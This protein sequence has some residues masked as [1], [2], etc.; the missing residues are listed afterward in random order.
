MSWSLSAFAD[1]AGPSTDEQIKALKAAGYN[2]IDLRNVDGFNITMLPLDKAK[3][4]R[5]KLD[6]AGITVGMYGS[7]IGK[8]DI[9]E[10]FNIDVEKLKH[11]GALRPILGA[12]NVRLFSYY[13]K[14]NK[15]KT[16]FAKVAL[17]RLRELAKIGKDL[18][19]VL[20]HEN[21]SHIFGDRCEDVLTIANTVR[22]DAFKMIFDFGNYNAGGENALENWKK[23]KPL[24]DAIHLK[25]NVRN[26]D[27][28]LHHVPAGQGGGFIKEILADAAKSGWT[29]PLTLEPHLTHS[30]AVMATGPSGVANQA[31]AAMTPA[32][33]FAIAAKT[34][35]DLIASVG[36]KVN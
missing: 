31:Y 6:A 9:T 14:A 18:G 22:G 16:E 36:G 7:P 1:E 30:A 32:E 24:T 15:P 27:G 23:L 12:T 28:K 11:L 20:Y 29:G 26:A 2:F 10:D 3:D 17:D 8:I 34:A 21:E 35:K 19:L 5:A 25:D 13:N 33:S 4:V